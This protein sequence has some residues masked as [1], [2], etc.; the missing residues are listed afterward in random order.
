[1]PRTFARAAAAALSAAVAAAT[2][3]GPAT[4]AHA[5]TVIGGYEL[6]SH[7]TL[8]HLGPGAK[9]LPTLDASSFV[10]A[11]LD[12]GE[13][14]AARDPHGRYMPASTIKVLT[15]I[16]LLPL[17]PPATRIEATYDDTA[18][19]GSRVGIVEHVK[20]SADDLF[21]AMLMVSGNDAAL[22][23]SHPVGG[24]AAT[25]VKM[26]AEA[27]RLQGFDT[28]VKTVN[29]LDAA[30]Q[31]S[32]AYDLALFGKA[33]L[34][35]PSFVS[36][37]MTKSA[38]FPAP[39]KQHFQIFTH[40][41]LL[42]N[43][44]GALGIKN[45]Y[46]VAAQATYIGAAGRNGHRLIV[47]LMHAQ[48]LVWHDAA[49]LLDWGFANEDKVTAVG[50]LVDPVPPVVPGTDPSAGPS[51]D[52]SSPAIV[53]TPPVTSAAAS[54][55]ISTNIPIALIGGIGGGVLL[56]GVVALWASRRRRDNFP[57]FDDIDEGDRLPHSRRGA[58]TEI[59]VPPTPEP[60][61]TSNIRVRRSD[62]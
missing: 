53:A 30:G 43:Y 41:K 45:G 60:T 28:T 57:S 50:T 52:P 42:L 29:G 6:A 16:T 61:F 48:P 14:L 32:S 8:V 56:A 36:Y 21:R 26:T 20:Y 31:R 17:I 59:V 23:L 11:D 51:V 39:R 5:V 55:G 33:G 13:I 44:D 3:W 34:Q 38:E 47:T 40:D 35:I 24:P 19:D 25:I 46:T 2:C 10:L 37:V 7:R 54:A 62:E 12:T 15:A 4:P 18:V 58:I 1:M 27:K 49:A 9:P 22:A